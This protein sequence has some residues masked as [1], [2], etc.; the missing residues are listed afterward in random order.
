[1]VIDPDRR[2]YD[3][4]PTRRALLEALL[5]REG[6]AQTSAPSHI[7]RLSRR[8]PGPLSFAQERLWFLH[9]LAPESALYNLDTAVGLPFVPDAGLLRRALNEIVRRHEALRTTFQL[10]D[11]APVQVVA[12]RLELP[13]QVVDLRDR[14][15]AERDAEAARWAA[16]ESRLSFNLTTGPLIRAALIILDDDRSLYF[17]CLHHIVFDEWSSGV[18][19]AELTALYDAFAAGR[20]SP[21]PELPIQYPDFAVWQRAWLLRGPEL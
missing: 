19:T 5:R 11:G 3:L 7:P 10:V 18:F 4:S 13:L 17:H 14:P 9:Q 12:P 16:T 2:A 15:A 1:M 6:I 8:Q 21:L 20:P